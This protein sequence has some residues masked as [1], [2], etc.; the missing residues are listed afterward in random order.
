MSDLL[1]LR[2]L[3]VPG[4]RHLTGL[5]QE[6]PLHTAEEGNAA[7]CPVWEDRGGHAALLPVTQWLA[8]PP[9]E[10][11]GA[12]A[13]SQQCARL[14]RCPPTLGQVGAACGLQT[15]RSHG[16]PSTGCKPA[17]TVLVPALTDPAHGSL[18]SAVV[19]IVT[20]PH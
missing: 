17:S 2:F 19:V 16:T 20:R 1:V 3:S 9:W 7:P 6:C 12:E 10:E 11:A 4:S 13:S 8:H 5:G 15:E 18:C 14:H